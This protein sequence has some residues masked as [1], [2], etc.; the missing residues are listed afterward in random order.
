MVA[1]WRFEGNSEIIENYEVTPRQMRSS[2]TLADLKGNISERTIGL[3]SLTV[4]AFRILEGMEG[5]ESASPRPLFE[6][7]AVTTIPSRHDLFALPTSRPHWQSF[8]KYI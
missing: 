3:L 6:N 8:R 4:I 2:R 7:H 5:M 1:Y